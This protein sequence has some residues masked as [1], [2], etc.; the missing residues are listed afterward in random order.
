[1]R[2]P[3]FCIHRENEQ[4]D[5]YDNEAIG[6]V[7]GRPGRPGEPAEAPDTVELRPSEPDAFDEVYHS[8]HMTGLRSAGREHP[9]PRRYRL[10]KELIDQIA[11]RSREDKQPGGRMPR[12]LVLPAVEE[13]KEDG[14]S[15]QIDTGDRSDRA[16]TENE[17]VIEDEAKANQI[18]ALPEDG[19][20]GRSVNQRVQRRIGGVHQLMMREVKVQMIGNDF[21]GNEIDGNKQG[22]GR[23]PER[24]KDR[25][26]G[27]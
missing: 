26:E 16:R 9:F 10:H 27:S 19:N 1:M 11:H 25:Q 13:K 24:R 17:A 5:T 20:V 12:R 8:A 3:L 4:A 7:K 22:E 21:L 18:A 14:K 15:G 23:K 2:S 6:N